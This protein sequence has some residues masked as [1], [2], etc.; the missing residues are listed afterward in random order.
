MKIHEYQGKEILREFG[1]PTPRGVACFSVDDAVAAAISL[2]GAVWVVKAQIHAGGRGKGGGVKV[3]H[4]LEEVRSF[5][6]QILGMH[7]VTHQTG[8]D[9]QVVRRL[10]I[11]EGA[12]IA[13]EFY[14]GMVIDRDT[15]RVAL[16][17]SSEGGMEIEE[18]AKNSPE[19]IH[20]LRIDPAAGLT[21]K[22]A[23]EASRLIGI[24][25]ASIA[26]AVVVLQGLYRAFVEK[27]A[28]LAE[29]NPLVLTRD[30]RVIALDAKF[31]FDSN[32]LFHHPE[33]VAYR[34]LDEE[35]PAEIEA[36]KFD[37]SYISLDGDIAC[38]VNGAGL[39]MATMDIIKLY[40]GN[41]ANFL[42]V[43]GGAN[44]EKVT[45]AFKLM[46]KN[47]GLKAILVNIFGGI[48]KCDVIAE[49]IVAAVR[50][51]H[52]HV[53]LVVRL[54]GTNV[55]LGKKI[56]ADSGLPIIS[57]SDMADAAQKVVAAA[58]GI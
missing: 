29:I 12:Q 27:E 11:E 47:P 41:P 24:P 51:V 17:A 35:D 52:L 21:D 37:L 40:G 13:R 50:E 15:Q 49:G 22:Q 1:V 28:M 55:E 2:G 33:V 30:G 8:I 48:M 45:E 14:L 9:G 6:G 20:T 3:A 56:L 57:A 58:R 44:R 19:K 26:A 53:P 36:S 46:L 39:A 54:E 34:D 5:A 18:V 42:D 16:L 43:G 7:L 31:N 4:S 10:L 38:L 32:A 23:A 25:D